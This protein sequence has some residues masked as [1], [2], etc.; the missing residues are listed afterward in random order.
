VRHSWI[1]GVMLMG[2]LS[3]GTGLRRDG[4]QTASEYAR[5]GSYRQGFADHENGLSAELPVR[6][7]GN[8][9]RA[10]TLTA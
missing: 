9:R 10:L 4:R 2:C 5:H 7:A 6:A 1:A 3:R 8:R